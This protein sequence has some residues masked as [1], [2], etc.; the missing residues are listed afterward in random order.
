MA[1]IF[2]DEI[3]QCIVFFSI[4]QSAVMNKQCLENMGKVEGEPEIMGV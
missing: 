2:D 4:V 1:N 3:Q